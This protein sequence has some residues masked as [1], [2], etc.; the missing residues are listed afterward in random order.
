MG[1]FEVA[2]SDTIGIAHPG[3]VPLVIGAVTAQVPIGKIALHFH[4]TRG[5]ALANVLASGWRAGIAL[6]AI[7]LM[8][9]VLVL[10]KRIARSAWGSR[11]ARCAI[12][13][14]PRRRW[15]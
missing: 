4:D 12:P 2:V 5:T 1:A 3:Q 8:A 11:C 14:S 9:I 10:Y 15:L 6:V 13:R 7:L